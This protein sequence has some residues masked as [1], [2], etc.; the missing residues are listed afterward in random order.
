VTFAALFEKHRT[1]KP[2]AYGA[3]YDALP[4]PA[5]VLELGIKTG[6]SLLAWAERWPDAAV[7]GMDTVLGNLDP[8]V[9][10]HPRVVVVEGDATDPSHAPADLLF[11]LIVDDVGYTS[12]EVSDQLKIMRNYAARVRPGGTY[13]VEDITTEEGLSELIDTASRLGFLAWAVLHP[14]GLEFRV[15]VLTKEP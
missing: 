11:D 1:E 2:R 13:V 9:R 6:R 14:P 8:G 7:Y 12:H 5:R 15:L 4:A 3:V 10:A